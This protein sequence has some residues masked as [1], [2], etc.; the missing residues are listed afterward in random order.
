[1]RSFR[2]GTPSRD[3]GSRLQIAGRQSG[4]PCRKSAAARLWHESLRLA[5]TERL[6]PARSVLD[7]R[8][9]RLAATLSDSV[10]QDAQV[11]WD[12]SDVEMKTDRS[13]GVRQTGFTDLFRDAQQVPEYRG[14]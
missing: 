6:P 8:R 4:A 3:G 11:L 13:V 14:P 2:I 9:A 5:P 12:R 7:R 1:M 10:M